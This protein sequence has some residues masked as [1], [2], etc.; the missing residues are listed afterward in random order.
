M[1]SIDANPFLAISE[2]SGHLRIQQQVFSGYNVLPDNKETEPGGRSQHSSHNPLRDERFL[3]GL[4][5]RDSEWECT[6]TL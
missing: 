1:I 2:L 6:V 5:W 3:E 4:Y